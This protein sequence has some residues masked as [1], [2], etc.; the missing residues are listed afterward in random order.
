MSPT[1]QLMAMIFAVIAY[2]GLGNLDDSGDLF[3]LLIRGTTYC[4]YT[5]IY[6]TRGSAIAV[7]IVSRYSATTSH[8]K[9]KSPGP[10]VW[11]YR[12]IADGR[13]DTRRQDVPRLA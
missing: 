11:H 3:T 6:K 5:L 10:I 12:W 13:T 2:T 7:E 8:L 4:T 9:T 1:V